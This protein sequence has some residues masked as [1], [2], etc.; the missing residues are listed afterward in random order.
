MRF[1]P[2][3]QKS[4][5]QQ[6]HDALKESQRNESRGT[7]WGHETFSTP[8]RY[9]S[10]NGFRRSCGLLGNRSQLHTPAAVPTKEMQRQ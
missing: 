2:Q 1:K 9:I 8:L 5:G 4:T 3:G 6:H 10:W 7:A